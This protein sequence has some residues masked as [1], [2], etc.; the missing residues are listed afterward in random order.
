MEIRVVR[1]ADVEEHFIMDK[2]LYS[3]D[4]VNID[5]ISDEARQKFVNIYEDFSKRFVESEPT[6]QSLSY[7]LN[8]VVNGGA[9]LTDKYEKI[10]FQVANRITFYKRLH[11]EAMREYKK[12]GLIKWYDKHEYD[13][14]I[15]FE[16]P[17][18]LQ[19]AILADHVLR[20]KEKIPTLRKLSRLRCST[21]K[22]LGLEKK[23]WVGF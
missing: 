21:R 6:L 23:A 10:A 13:G 1:I 20:H 5:K 14:E 19:M 3:F 16:T 15:K 2:N 4:Y 9:K 18:T 22:K 8:I 7:A 12:S 11:D 17:Y